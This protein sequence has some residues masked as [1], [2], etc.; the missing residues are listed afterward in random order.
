MR[1]HY[2]FY[3]FLIFLVV[4]VFIGYFV[5]VRRNVEEAKLFSDVQVL[6][7][8]P[9]DSKVE[10]SSTVSSSYTEVEDA[11]SDYFDSFLEQYQTV[12]NYALDDKLISLLSVSNYLEDGPLFQNSIS[13]VEDLENNFLVDMDKL[14]SM[15]D[16][17]FMEEY[18]RKLEFSS[19]YQD[20]FLDVM[21]HTSI[22]DQFQ[23]YKQQFLESREHMELVFQTSLSVF[24]FLSSHVDDWKIENDEIQ[25]STEELV[26]EY[27]DLVSSVQ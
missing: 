10:I 9:L 16:E 18:A 22:F 21:V 24:A 14:L 20:L 26:N 5:I 11:V 17:D 15:C 1:R 3:F 13:Y 6:E 12:K 25:F 27:Q 23:N 2:L 19:Y 4:F 8:F 7:E